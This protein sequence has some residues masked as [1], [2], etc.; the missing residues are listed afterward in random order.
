MA[1][2]RYPGP[3]SGPLVIVAITVFIICIIGL[4][5]ISAYIIGIIGI[6]VYIIG[7][8]GMVAIICNHSID[9]PQ[10]FY[11]YSRSSK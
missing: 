11:R 10:I 1:L 9:I 2:A 8:R 5:C 6:V 4:T 7:I 3:E